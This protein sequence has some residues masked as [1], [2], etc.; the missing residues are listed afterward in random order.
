LKARGRPVRPP[1]P[2]IGRKAEAKSIWVLKRM[3]PPQREIIRQVRRITEGTEIN[4]VVIW[5]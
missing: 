3:E 2:N 1:I 5:K 4:T